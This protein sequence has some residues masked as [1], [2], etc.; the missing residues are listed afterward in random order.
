MA[1][2]TVYMRCSLWCGLATAVVTVTVVFVRV[3]VVEGLCFTC[4]EIVN[5]RTPPHLH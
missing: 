3:T 1:V 5:F 2:R 4:S